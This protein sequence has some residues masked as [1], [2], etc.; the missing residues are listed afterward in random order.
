MLR[1]KNDHAERHALDEAISRHLRY[2]QTPEAEKRYG[3]AD[4]AA[5]ERALRG[6]LD[7]LNRAVRREI[8]A[9]YQG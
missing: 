7:R 6:A 4:C 5:Q 8:N 9:L 1:I 2:L 3:A